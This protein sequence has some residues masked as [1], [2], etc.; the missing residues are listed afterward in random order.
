MN[1]TPYYIFLSHK[2]LHQRFAVFE[3]Q[4]FA[5]N[6]A[7]AC[8]KMLHFGEERHDSMQLVYIKEG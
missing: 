4:R 7:P 8:D 1:L 5:V 3:S 2:D 6:E